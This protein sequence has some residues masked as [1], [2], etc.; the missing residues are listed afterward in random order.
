MFDN[1]EKL[2]ILLV[3]AL[4]IFGPSKLAGFGGS[5]GKTLRDF[6]NA[7][8][9][10]Q[11]EARQTFSEFTQEASSTVHEMQQALP[12]PDMMET[13]FSGSTYTPDPVETP[14]TDHVAGDTGAAASAHP[15][16]EDPSS[17][18]SEPTAAALR[19]AV[20]QTQRPRF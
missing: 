4:L 19:E 17:L 18:A 11:D 14:S 16:A 12:A 2:V 1:P 9:D 10:A 20:Q 5:L 7:V 8:R 3:V 13:S 15:E 6:R